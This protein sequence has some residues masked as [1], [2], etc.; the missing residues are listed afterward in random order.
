MTPAHLTAWRDLLSHKKADTY[1]KS[2]LYNAGLPGQ[3]YALAGI[4]YTD[5]PCLMTLATPYLKRQDAV[6]TI[7]ACDVADTPVSEIVEGI[8]DGAW[9]EALRRGAPG[10]SDWLARRRLTSSA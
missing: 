2:L 8:V 7:V 4:Y 5:P 3:L 1:F 6:K 9:P 10:V